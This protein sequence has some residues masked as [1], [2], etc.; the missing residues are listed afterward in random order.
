MSRLSV[1]LAGAYALAAIS[2]CAFRGNAQE[3]VPSANLQVPAAPAPAEAPQ[4][5]KPNPTF[6][7]ATSPTADEVNAFLQTS[8]GYNVN[9]VWQ[10][11]AIMKTPVP[12]VSKVVVLV[13]NKG[14]RSKIQA[15]EF[16]TMPDNKHIIAGN[17]ILPFG[18]HPYA[19]DRAALEARADGPYRGSPS[20]DLELVEFA[21]FQCPKCDQVEANMDKLA[22]DFPSA[23]I[24]FENF[25]LANV[26]PQSARAAAYG[27]CVNKLGGSVPFFQFASAVYGGQAGL[28]TADGATL[29]LNSAVTKAG[30]DP[31]KV[32]ACASTPETAQEVESSVQLA[33]DLNINETPTLMVNGRKVP[34]GGV[35]YD[36]IKL[37]V[38]Y[39]AKLDGITVATP[40]ASPAKGD[41]PTTNP[42]GPAKPMNSPNR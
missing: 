38:E 36:T 16:F 10:V 17:V 27:V 1:R 5:P 15:L 40:A 20:K 35:P 8:W 34:L 6:F 32:A 11:Q 19:D 25:P 33:R 28:A 26:H 21:D 13:G 9:R 23:R 31:A 39:Q 3:Q 12:G 18:Q 24:V 41:E 2:L 4:F 14:G 7:T 29:T 42:P 30:L 22:T 37:I